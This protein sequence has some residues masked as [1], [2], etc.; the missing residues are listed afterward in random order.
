MIIENVK[1]KMIILYS[2]GSNKITDKERTFFSNAIFLP[3]DAD[4]SKYVEVPRDI[5]RPFVEND[6]KIYD[7]LDDKIQEQKGNM[8]QQ[9]EMV[10]TTMEAISELYETISNLEKKLNKLLGGVFNGNGNGNDLL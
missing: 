4:I 10:L 7:I 1:D 9:E 8:A 2:E 3:K 5:W 6:D